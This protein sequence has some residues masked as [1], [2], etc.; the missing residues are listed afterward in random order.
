MSNVQILNVTYTSIQNENRAASES[1]DVQNEFRGSIPNRFL[2]KFQK[3]EIPMP[4]LFSVEGE[5]YRLVDALAE[6]TMSSSEDAGG[7]IL[8]TLSLPF[9]LVDAIATGK[10]WLLLQYVPP[11]RVKTM[12]S[13]PGVPPTNLMN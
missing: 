8:S 6:K 3:P 1:S 13:H 2:V 11:D 9:R 5:F 12:M 10:S 4:D 7:I